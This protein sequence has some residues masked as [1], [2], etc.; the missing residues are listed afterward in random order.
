MPHLRHT[1]IG[2][3]IRPMRRSL[4]LVLLSFVI[5]GVGAASIEGALSS[6]LAAPKVVVLDKAGDAQDGNHMRYPGRGDIDIL[7]VEVTKL[8]GGLR[9]VI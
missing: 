4:I 8:A 3:M 9:I 7:R 5:V 2:R 6:S 1:A